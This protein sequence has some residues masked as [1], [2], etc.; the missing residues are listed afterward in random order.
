MKRAVVVAL[1]GSVL[2]AAAPAAAQDG[3]ALAPPAVAGE[4]DVPLGNK[5]KPFGAQAA[6]RSARRALRRR[7]YEDATASCARSSRRVASCTVAAVSGG[8][9]SGTADVTRGKR[10]DRVRYE[11]V[12]A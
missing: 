3:V 10:A 5:V 2:M 6:A 1:M 7:G 4:V 8:S 9:W 11:L 12:G